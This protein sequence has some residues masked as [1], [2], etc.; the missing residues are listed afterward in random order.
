[1]YWWVILLSE[2]GFTTG[3]FK[4]LLQSADKPS[5]MIGWATAGVV[6]AMESAAVHASASAQSRCMK[7]CNMVISRR[8]LC[9]EK[10]ECIETLLS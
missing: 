6:C 4:P 3:P 1:M 7:H 5:S 9:N 10:S 2:V 8:R